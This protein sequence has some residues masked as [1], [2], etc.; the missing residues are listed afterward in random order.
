MPTEGLF[1][2][3]PYFWDYYNGYAQQAAIFFLALNRFTAVWRPA[4]HR[5]MW[6]R[7]LYV[8]YVVVPV[9]PLPFTW[10]IWLSDVQIELEHEDNY[11]DGYRWDGFTKPFGLRKSMFN[12]PIS[13]AHGLL[14]LAMNLSVLAKLYVMRRQMSNSYQS[15]DDKRDTDAKLCIMTLILFA[16]S[17]VYTTVTTIFYFTNNNVPGWAIDLLYSIQSFG[18]DIHVLTAPWFLMLMSTAVRVELRS[19]IFRVSDENSG[20]LFSMATRSNRSHVLA[21]A[22]SNDSASPQNAVL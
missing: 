19:L 15:S 17:A 20:R 10:F 18:L 21:S 16:Y 13:L 1:I 3:L 7:L 12:V 2:T 14:L 5:K 6:K 8:V 22:R 4:G 9:F 11:W